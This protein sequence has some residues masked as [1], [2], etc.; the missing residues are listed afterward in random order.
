MFKT[1]FGILGYYFPKTLSEL[2]IRISY[3]SQQLYDRTHPH[4]KLFKGDET[5]RLE[6]LSIAPF[7]AQ[8]VPFIVNHTPGEMHKGLFKRILPD[9]KDITHQAAHELRA[10]TFNLLR[11]VEPLPCIED[12]ESVFEDWISNHYN[13]PLNVKSRIRK[14]RQE[15]LDCGLSKKDYRHSPF[16][17]R[18]FYEEMKAA[19]IICKAEDKF[20]AAVAPVIHACEQVVFHDSHLSKYFVKGRTINE[21]VDMMRRLGQM[22]GKFAETD[23]SRFEANYRD[24]T[25]K[26]IEMQFWK[27]MLRHNPK[28]LDIMM[29]SY[30]YDRHLY[31][32]Q[33]VAIFRGTR[34]SG[35]LWTSL[36]NGFTNLVVMKAVAKRVGFTFEGLFEGDDGLCCYNGPDPTPEDFSYYGFEIKLEVKDEINQCSF[37][38]KIFSPKTN[39][40]LADPETVERVSWTPDPAHFLY[41]DKSRRRLACEKCVAMLNIYPRT[42]VGSIKWLAILRVLGYNRKP[43]EVHDWYYQSLYHTTTLVKENLEYPDIQYEDRLLYWQRFGVSP[44]Y[45]IIMENEFKSWEYRFK[46][47][48]PSDYVYSFP[49]D[50]LSYHEGLVRVP[51]SKLMTKINPKHKI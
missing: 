2:K 36:M 49:L 34:M 28:T 44:E 41:G 26:A 3:E 4:L 38:T 16:V 37:L 9:H 32:R 10:Q 22:T 45:Q 51:D 6:A 11:G 25:F 8:Y 50:N 19:R 1:R 46:D 20:V 13:K 48:F 21:Q 30:Q 43:I 47:G 39:N 31:S 18:E 5:Q 12:D 23:H 14:A 15:Y 35:D 42:P 17:K 29:K 24:K 27:H 40:L 7:N 33:A